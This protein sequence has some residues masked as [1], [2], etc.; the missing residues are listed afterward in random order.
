MDDANKIWKN[1]IDKNNINENSL[2]YDIL[3]SEYYTDYNDIYSKIQNKLFTKDTMHW[4]PFAYIYNLLSNETSNILKFRTYVENNSKALKKD[5][6]TDD[7]IKSIFKEC[8]TQDTAD[9]L[10]NINISVNDAILEYNQINDNKDN[11][12]N[13]DT[14]MNIFNNIY[15]INN[16]MNT[17]FEKLPKCS[18]IMHL[19]TDVYDK[20][21][22]KPVNDNKKLFTKLLSKYNNALNT[23]STIKYDTK[24]WNTIKKWRNGPKESKDS[25]NLYNETNNTVY[26]SLIR[27]LHISIWIQ[28]IFNECKKIHKGPNNILPYFTLFKNFIY[29]SNDK[30][31]LISFTNNKELIN[32]INNL[33]KMEYTIN[34]P[35]SFNI[36]IIKWVTNRM[37]NNK[38]IDISKDIKD[39]I[40]YSEDGHYKYKTES[41]KYIESKISDKNCYNLH[42]SKN[43]CMINIITLLN[44]N[45]SFVDCVNIIN[46]ITHNQLLEIQKT[47]NELNPFIIINILKKFNFQ[48]TLFHSNIYNS[49]IFQIQS[50]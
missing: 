44:N 8:L 7:T 30:Y 27:I 17:L 22:T 1:I 41:G 3:R 15:N 34:K 43:N 10:T 32:E 25:Q 14:N 35:T 29:K 26:I 12:D 19:Y 21:K 42:F 2:S 33:I 45:F 36:D 46:E 13:K 50:F 9:T 11:K 48:K 40:W 24:I 49:Q 47:I 37:N 16:Y 28:N 38:I 23:K 39:D 6:L 4:E 18:K 5:N 20:L 31:T